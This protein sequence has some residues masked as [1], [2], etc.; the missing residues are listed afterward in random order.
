MSKKGLPFHTIKYFILNATT[1]LTNTEYVR[2]IHFSPLN[3][4][5]I[6]GIPFAILMYIFFALDTV[7]SFKIKNKE[8]QWINIS[9]VSY[10]VLTFTAATVSTHIL[11]WFILGAL[12][13][14]NGLSNYSNKLN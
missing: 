14:S 1:Y 9:W 12:K 11:T 4:S 13:Y 7:K 8:L 5:F 6:S 3:Y 10:F 2:Y